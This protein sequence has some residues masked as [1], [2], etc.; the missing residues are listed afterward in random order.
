LP[1][2]NN[3]SHAKIA[4]SIYWAISACKTVCWPL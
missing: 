1:E 3:V 2:H 4:R